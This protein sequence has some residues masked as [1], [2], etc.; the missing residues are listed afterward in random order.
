MPTRLVHGGSITALRLTWTAARGPLVGLTALELVT[1]LLPVGSAWAVKLALDRLADPG[2]AQLEVLAVAFAVI[3]FVA[4]S[5]AP[6][7]RFLQA[8]LRRA[9]A[10]SAKANLYAAVARLQ[11]L[12]TLEKPSFRDRLRLAEQASQSGPAQVVESLIA[13]ARTVVT[14]CGM[15]AT[16]IA[17]Q[18]WLA[19][20]L[21]AAAIPALIAELKLS[22]RRMDMMWQIS[23]T[24]R[25]E[26]FFTDLI[27]SLSAAKE[28][29]LFGAHRL[30]RHRMLAEL[31]SS[32]RVRRHTDRRELVVQ[33]A[34][35][36]LSAGLLAGT[37]CWA[38]LAAAAGQLSPGDIGAMVIVA[39]GTQSSLAA[40]VGY[41]ASGHHANLLTTH[42]R[43][44]VAASPPNESQGVQQAVPST[45][46]GI[47]LD[48]VWFRYDDE[49]PWAL[50]GVT[51]TIPTGRSLALVGQN[52]SGK[53]TLIKLLCRFY[54]PTRG[55][56]YW[57]G[58]DLRDLPIEELR[59]RIGAVFQDFMCY[60]LTARENIALGDVDGRDE[61]NL[62]DDRLHAAAGQA[63][64]LDVLKALPRGADTLLS[65]TF[66]DYDTAQEQGVLLSGG[67]WQ[68]L[69]LARALL[70]GQRDLL[71]L[72]EPSSGLD[73]MAEQR[74]HRQLAEHRHGRTSI[75]ISHRLNTVRDAD[76]IVVLDAG[77]IVERGTHST[78]V[79]ADG[80]Y[81]ELFRMQAEGYQ[82][83]ETHAG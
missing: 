42:Y 48:D 32:N 35:A 23:P 78:L 19:G 15:L 67:Q 40:L 45:R 83:T 74:I 1:G 4:A 54:D 37:L 64:I 77:Q 69:A 2:R 59:Q 12:S 33:S 63:E 41:I 62:T 51:L 25:R 3:T 7:H 6:L 29:R 81:A 13:G 43:D 52:G 65:R 61:F 75:L 79:D 60:E 55:A 14:L 76:E 10:V 57:D 34:L 31:T 38:L 36:M 72:D 11:M 58:I 18:P 80:C 44:L 46:S 17:I 71:I 30:F 26:A 49:Q 47:E 20:V 27:T 66:V 53:S 5:A 70:R 56:I 24:E 50:R 22:G 73:A 16:V 39:G 8:E 68:R 82:T 28:S 9:V 21:V